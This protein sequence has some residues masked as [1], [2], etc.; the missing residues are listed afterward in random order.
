MEVRHQSQK[1]ESYAGETILVMSALEPEFMVKRGFFVCSVTNVA[2][3]NLKL[4]PNDV[5]YQGDHFL[6]WW[7][8]TKVT[9]KKVIYKKQFSPYLQLGPKLKVRGRG[10]R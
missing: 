6:L 7:L 2:R 3:I 4:L 5:E 8:V 1:Q 9:S 10:P